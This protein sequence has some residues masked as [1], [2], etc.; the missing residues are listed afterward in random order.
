MD[1][2]PSPSLHQG[3]QTTGMA[4]PFLEKDRRKKLIC[5][6]DTALSSVHT[7]PSRFAPANPTS[8][9]STSTC[10]KCRKKSLHDKKYT[11]WPWVKQLIPYTNS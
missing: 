2:S 7:R 6:Q 3:P 10:D 4:G 8:F 1:P 11:L 9:G 5:L